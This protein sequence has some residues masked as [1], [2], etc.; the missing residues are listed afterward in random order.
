METCSLPSS[1]ACSGCWGPALQC[2]VR[3]IRRGNSRDPPSLEGGGK[4]SKAKPS[5]FSLLL[6]PNHSRGFSPL[7]RSFVLGFSSGLNSQ[8]RRKTNVHDLPSWYFSSSLEFSESREGHYG[9]LG[10]HACPQSTKKLQSCLFTQSP[11]RSIPSIQTKACRLK[12]ISL[13]K[14]QSFILP[15]KYSVP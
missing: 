14:L 7:S 8:F 9:K 4:K 11:K 3:K 5:L 12:T 1:S 15:M 6:F 2:A 13:G 10:D